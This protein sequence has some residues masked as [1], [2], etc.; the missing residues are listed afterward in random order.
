[1]LTLYI[2]TCTC[3]PIFHVQTYNAESS[4]TQALVVC[5]APSEND[6][7]YHFT[8]T[9]ECYYTHTYRHSIIKLNFV[10]SEFLTIF[11]SPEMVAVKRNT[12]VSN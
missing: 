2:Q 9:S 8:M 1:M 6:I 4:P 10:I 7:I 5:S 3:P 11:N 12:T